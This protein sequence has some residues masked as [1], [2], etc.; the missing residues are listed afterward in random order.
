MATK[1]FGKDLTL[2]RE[3]ILGLHTNM[4]PLC[5]VARSGLPT[6]LLMQTCASVREA[7]AKEK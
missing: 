5:H 2:P 4:Q 7:R 1:K 3:K 6:L